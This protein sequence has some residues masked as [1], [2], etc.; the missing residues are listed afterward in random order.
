M[1]RPLRGRHEGGWI[2]RNTN[3]ANCVEDGTCKVK[4]QYYQLKLLKMFKIQI[5]YKRFAFLNNILP[6]IADKHL[7]Q[8]LSSSLEGSYTGIVSWC[9][10]HGG[11]L[12]TAKW[13]MI[14]YYWLAV[15]WI[16]H[17]IARNVD[18]IKLVFIFIHRPWTGRQQVTPKHLYL[19]TNASILWM[20]QSTWKY[21]CRFFSPW[22]CTPN[23][24]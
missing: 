15:C 3:K 21:I 17:Y 5:N 12:Y 19:S 16:K 8:L 14:I 4:I 22:W 13:R 10:R 18:Y 20:I 2:K 9:L 24:A 7:Y 23:R 1:F 6:F 11:L